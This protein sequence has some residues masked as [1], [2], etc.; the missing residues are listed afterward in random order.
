MKERLV[1]DTLIP[2][3]LDLVEW[4]DREPRPYSEAIE[5]WRTSCPRLTVWEDAFERG[6]VARVW[7]PDHGAIVMT[8][9]L[10]QRLLREHGRSV[11]GADQERDW[12][13]IS[14]A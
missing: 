5:V 9:D 11:R 6:Y 2:L 14:R 13:L 4:V 7:S 10:G 12:A 1:V 8:T 3:V